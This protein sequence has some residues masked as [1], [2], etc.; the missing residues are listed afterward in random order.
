MSDY[1]AIEAAERNQERNAAQSA[2]I[3]ELEKQVERV[4]VEL[5]SW[6]MRLG[7]R[8]SDTHAFDYITFIHAKAAEVSAE[9]DRAVSA[10]KPFSEWMKTI[11]PAMS[12]DLP[13][14]IEVT[15]GELRA[16]ASALSPTTQ[17]GR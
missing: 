11:A 17:E 7:Y 16:A 13:K 8:D 6:A 3:A 1:D 14:T 12:D 2:R 5:K 4:R 9:R 10:L 15:C